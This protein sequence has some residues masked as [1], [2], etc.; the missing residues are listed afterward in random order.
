MSQNPRLPR[1]EKTILKKSDLLR[2]LR[3]IDRSTRLRERV[4]ALETELRRRVAVHAA[5]LPARSAALR[6]FATSP[7]VLMIYA[8][9]KGYRHVS[10][11]EHDILPAKLFSSMETSAGRM[12]QDVALPAY[13][14]ESVKSSM[15]SEMSVIDAR[16]RTPDLLQ[17][18][19]LKSGPRCLNDEMSKDI[20]DDIVS[21]AES[22]AHEAEVDHIEFTYAALY[23]T[24][25]QSNKK[26][27]HVLDNIAQTVGSRF[28]LEAPDH[29]W[30]CAFR[31]RGIR[32]DVVVR[33]GSEWWAFLGGQYALLELL[34]ALVRACVPPGPEQDDADYVI[35]DLGRIVS[36]ET[37]PADYN[38]SLL[39]RS[40]LE[41][42]FFLASH[43]CD[44]L[45]D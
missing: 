35:E 36:L 15:H 22:W 13:G 29:V 44:V 2:E 16:K 39:Q 43:Y 10:E 6:K 27:W 12:V 5:R 3:A 21:H 32:V 45:E 33:I 1:I 38:V 42:L 18:A 26:D 31:I 30:N 14:W 9:Q 24:R 25:K 8:A 11:I 40:Q 37:V 7:F 17:L 19:T 34:C 41:W 23:G 4:L 20:A 28:V